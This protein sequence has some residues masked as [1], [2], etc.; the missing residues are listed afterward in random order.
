MKKLTNTELTETVKVDVIF[1]VLYDVIKPVKLHFEV[2]MLKDDVKGI[3]IQEWFKKML[4]NKLVI[5]STNNIPET[6]E[7]LQRFF[8]EIFTVQ[9]T[10][11][12]YICKTI[13]F[14][15][16]SVSQN[17]IKTFRYE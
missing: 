16:N 6:V 3:T 14:I 10:D 1:N 5:S 7:P 8:P 12:D 11:I 4:E 2:E 13:Y 17:N 15:L 9:N